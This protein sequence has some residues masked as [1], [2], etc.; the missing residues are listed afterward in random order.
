LGRRRAKEEFQWHGMSAGKNGRTTTAPSWITCAIDGLLW[1]GGTENVKQLLEQMARKGSIAG[2][3]KTRQL[4]RVALLLREP[5][6]L[7]LW[8][9]YR[10][11][12]ELDAIERMEEPPRPVRRSV[13]FGLFAGVE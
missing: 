7:P 2:P 8:V 9:R 11:R 5:G 10:T 6:P 4:P 13:L 3:Y 12:R 1:K